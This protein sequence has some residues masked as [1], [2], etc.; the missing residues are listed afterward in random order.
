MNAAALQSV[1]QHILARSALCLLVLQPALSL[2]ADWDIDRLM[3]ALAVAKPGRATFVEKKYLS[4][5]DG[6]VQSSGELVYTAPD[7]LEKRTLKPKP[8]IMLVEGGVLVIERGR[9][10]HTLQLQ[11]YP[12]LGVF[13]DSIRGTLAGDRKALERSYKLKLEGSAERWTL[14]LFPTDPRMATTIHL[15]R[16]AGRRANVRNIDVIQTDGDRSSMTID[17][18]A[19]Q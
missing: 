11:D 7:R 4:V 10:K 1:F 14:L 5:V 8:E 16:I 17:R 6:P 18:S 13:I 2:A 12:E 9:Q 3:Q 19:P 15:I